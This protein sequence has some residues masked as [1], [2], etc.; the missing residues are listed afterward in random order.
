MIST[1]SKYIYK[2]ISI[3]YAHMSHRYIYV[4][5]NVVMKRGPKRFRCYDDKLNLAGN[6]S[7]QVSDN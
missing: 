7:N 2:N 6:P 1:V 4:I 5:N 3:R